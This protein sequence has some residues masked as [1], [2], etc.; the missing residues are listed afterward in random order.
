MQR[1]PF[2]FSPPGRVLC[3]YTL[4]A[5]EAQAAFGAP[6]YAEGGPRSLPGWG[7]TLACGLDIE[8]QLDAANAQALLH[9]ELRELEHAL[10]HLAIED[11][12]VWRMD[13]DRDAFERALEEY[14]PVS[15]GRWTVARRTADGDI[16]PVVRCLSPADAQCHAQELQQAGQPAFVEQ[17]PG[18]RAR[19]RRAALTKRMAAKRKAQAVAWE[20]WWTDATGSQSL[21]QISPSEEAARAWQQQA[22]A[23]R[24]GQWQVRR[25]A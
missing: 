8:I 18:D 6:H 23:Q 4:S 16:E 12:I 15:W 25:R 13:E 2:S 24:G 3:R 14:H 17:E 10:R 5:E 19:E 20:V 9:A 21:L 7:F 1:A 11:R 22:T